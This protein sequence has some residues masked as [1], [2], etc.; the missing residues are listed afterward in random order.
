MQY[1]PFSLVAEAFVA[2]DAGGNAYLYRMELNHSH[3][4]ALSRGAALYGAGGG[5]EPTI[6]ELMASAALSDGSHVDLVDLDELPDDAI[7]LPMAMIGAPTVAVEKLPRG[8][9]GA[10]LKEHTEKLLGREVAALICAELG[11]INGVLPV[12]WAAQTG[13]PLVDG[14]LIGR[15]FPGVQFV[16]PRLMGYDPSPIV[17]IDERGNVATFHVISPDW[18]ARLTGAMMIASGAVMALSMYPMTVKE[19]KAGIVRGSMSQAIHAGQ[20]LLDGGDDPVETLMKEVDGVSLIEGKVTDVDRR[21]ESGFALG[22]AVIEG[23]GR[24]AG[25]ALRLEFQNENLVAFKDGVVVA[26]TPDIITVVDLHSGWPIVTEA[27]RYGQRVAVV[28]IPCAPIWRTEV[29]LSVAGPAAFGYDVDYTPAE[30][31]HDRVR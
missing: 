11:G 30:V 10:R 16:V 22:S 13:L 24:H 1:A 26:T 7:I 17:Q 15:A 14:D 18:A 8:D 25:S 29:G 27:L 5:G 3:I 9:E 12:A 31:A 2:C 6:G 20:L 23:V 28:D 19:A 21:T 4:P